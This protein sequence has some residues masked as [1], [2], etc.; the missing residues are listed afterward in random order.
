[1]FSVDSY[2]FPTHSKHLYS[3]CMEHFNL[4]VYSAVFLHVC[5]FGL[6]DFRKV[7][8]CHSLKNSCS[9]SHAYLMTLFLHKIQGQNPCSQEI[10]YSNLGWNLNKMWIFCT[11][12]S[13]VSCVHV[14]V[15][16]KPSLIWKNVNLESVLPLCEQT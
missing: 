15:Q 14:S 12:V 2:T 10:P 13:F 11:P 7:F 4:N 3:E 9:I 5:V 1:M 8:V 6:T 16:I